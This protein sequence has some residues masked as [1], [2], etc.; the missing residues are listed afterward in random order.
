MDISTRIDNLENLVNGLIEDINR[1]KF[2][3][4]ADI[5]GCRQNIEEVTPYTKSLRAYYR[6]TE[7]VFYNV[8]EGNVT[9]FFDNYSGAYSVKRIEDRLIVSFDAL[10]QETKITISIM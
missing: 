5:A 4:D 10:E 1:I 7:K 9:V 2:Y 8:P 3:L 6:E